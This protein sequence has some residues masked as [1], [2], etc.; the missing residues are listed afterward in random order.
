MFFQLHS[1][2]YW[3]KNLNHVSTWVWLSTYIENYLAQIPRRFYSAIWW[4]YGFCLWVC[5]LKKCNLEPIL[6]F[7]K[8]K[9]SGLEAEL[10]WKN[11]IKAFNNL[12]GRNYQYRQ[13]KNKLSSL[14]KGWQLWNTLIGKE[15]DLGWDPMR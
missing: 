14:K 6:R 2:S 1:I 4:K 15:T 8:Q 10:G 5:W 3:Y 7:W 11:V 13:L 9:F 12:T